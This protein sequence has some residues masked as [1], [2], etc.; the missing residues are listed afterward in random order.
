MSKNVTISEGTQAKNFYN[1][2]KLRTNLIGGGTQLW[3]PEDEAGRYAN[4]GEA[5][6]DE[7]GTYT[8]ADEG[9]DGFSSVTVNVEGGGGG[10]GGDPVLITKEI[11]ENGTYDAKDDEADGYSS[12]T[13]NVT[14]PHARIL[15][16]GL[17]DAPVNQRMSTKD[18]FY[19]LHEQAFAAGMS[20]FTRDDMKQRL[21]TYIREGGWLN[22]VAPDIY[23]Y[24]NLV[25]VGAAGVTSGDMYGY[26]QLKIW[27]WMIGIMDESAT[28]TL[29]NLSVNGLSA[30]LSDGSKFTNR[31]G[32]ISANFNHRSGGINYEGYRSVKQDIDNHTVGASGVKSATYSTGNLRI[33]DDYPHTQ[34]LTNLTGGT[35]VT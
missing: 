7:N 33:F 35:L 2:A 31:N 24:N 9:L 26:L 32:G 10:G 14:V 19:D 18:F 21:Q 5:T 30:T 20:Y 8:A 3:I 4:L 22:E 13:V 16:N 28:I 29:S 23:N 17:N 11:T 1:T 27:V 6:I 15:V 25:L 34:I 12:V